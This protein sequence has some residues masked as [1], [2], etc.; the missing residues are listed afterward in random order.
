MGII[1]LMIPPMCMARLFNELRQN[2]SP[3]DKQ[4]VAY[5]VAE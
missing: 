3:F 1:V 4:A 5:P 2:G